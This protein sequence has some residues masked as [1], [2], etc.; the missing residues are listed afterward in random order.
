M[1]SV[2]HRGSKI[3]SLPQVL[4]LCEF[5]VNGFFFFHC[6]LRSFSPTYSVH[7]QHR[8]L[9]F[10]P[11]I[12]NTLPVPEQPVKIFEPFAVSNHVQF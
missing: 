7:K 10:F 12:A 11:V 3:R 1:R 5:L 2:K 4:S 6:A 9:F 8:K